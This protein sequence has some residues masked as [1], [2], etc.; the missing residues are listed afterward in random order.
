[1]SESKPSD[2][3]IYRTIINAPI[4]KVWSEL[5]K[6][7]EVLPFF[8]GAVCDCPEF[9][10]GASFAMRSKNGKYTNVVG[11]VLEFSPPYKY[12]H[13]FKFTAY[14]DEP[15]TITYELKET[16]Q[17]VEFS[18]TTEDAPSGSK[19][20]KSM[21]QGGDFIVQN[22]KSVVENGKPT[23]SGRC[24]LLMIGLT[25]MF[26]PRSSRSENWPLTRGTESNQEYNG[27]ESKHG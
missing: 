20:E 21:D 14:D 2:K 8:F 6:T 27:E 24:I 22:F 11:K 3:R 7:D 17:G 10:V 16:E 25:E 9:E 23:F 15:C 4:E 19:T 26:S 18:L 5:V 12:S 13:T 1:M